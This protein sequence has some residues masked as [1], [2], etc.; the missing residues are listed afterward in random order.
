MAP[1]TRFY[2]YLALIKPHRVN[3]MDNTVAI[4]IY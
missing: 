3:R 1:D 4:Y 2:R